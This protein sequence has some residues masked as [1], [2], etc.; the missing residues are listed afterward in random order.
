MMI[1]NKIKGMTGLEFCIVLLLSLCDEDTKPE[2]R[3]QYV[4]KPNTMKVYMHYMPW[5]QSKEVS[6]YWGSH[7]RMANKNPDIVDANGKRQIASHYYPL[8]GP[9]DS[10]DPDVIEYHLLLM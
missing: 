8:I 6:G 7:W 10:K 3:P 2:H 9:Y 1:S 4:T 5:F